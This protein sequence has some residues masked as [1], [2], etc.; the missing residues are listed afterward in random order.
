[1]IYYDLLIESDPNDTSDSN[2]TMLSLKDLPAHLILNS[3]KLVFLLSIVLNLA[4][5]LS[6]ILMKNLHQINILILNLAVADLMHTMTIPVFIVQTLEEEFNISAVGCRLFFLSDFVSMSVCA[7]TVA[8]LSVERFHTIVY[9]KKHADTISN[10]FKIFITLIYLTLI[11]LVS[12]LFPLPYT[13]SL[14]QSLE[15]GIVCFSKWKEFSTNF[16]FAMEFLLIF[17][18]PYA[19]I[20]VASVKLLIFLQRWQKT[21]SR[22]FSLAVL[23]NRTTKRSASPSIDDKQ[24][25]DTG[26]NSKAKSQTGNTN[27]ETHILGDAA[28]LH[29]T[30]K[31]KKSQKSMLNNGATRPSI[32]NRDKIQ[33]KSTRT[34]LMIVL[35]FVIQWMPIWFVE[36]IMAF[37]M[38]FSETQLKYFV[39]VSTSLTYSNSVSNPII[40][41]L[42]TCNF[43]RFFNKFVKLDIGSVFK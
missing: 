30:T 26:E 1:M 24:C 10:K 31:R 43:K 25:C 19:F 8:A 32:N 38:S 14:N 20:L 28:T 22:Y 35:L 33:R 16:Y 29:K 2:S 21:T 17:L 23:L 34:V 37:N 6:I 7:F 9:Y 12:V 5:I 11:W 15:N 3:L 42:N 41:M 18:L 40:Y 27:E 36:M 13:L 39:F 4:T